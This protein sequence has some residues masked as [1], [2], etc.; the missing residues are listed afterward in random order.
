MAKDYP[1]AHKQSSIIVGQK[2]KVAHVRV[3]NETSHKKIDV[4]VPIIPILH[5]DKKDFGFAYDHYHLDGRFIGDNSKAGKIWK[6]SNGYTAAVITAENGNIY[7]DVFYKVKTCLFQQTGVGSGGKIGAEWRKSMV[8][9]SCKGKKCPHWGAIMS[10]I[11][12]VLVCPMHGLHGSLE[13]EVII[14]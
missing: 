1:I 12:G 9:K 7:S 5:N 4:E 6:T 11:D 3:I 14:Y 8:G 10:N 2:Y 13:E